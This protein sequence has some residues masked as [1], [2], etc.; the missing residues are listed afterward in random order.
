MSPSR[1]RW[2]SCRVGLLS[3][4]WL[5]GH[6]ALV[7]GVALVVLAFRVRGL[8]RREDRRVACTRE[9]ATNDHATRRHKHSCGRRPA[10]HEPIR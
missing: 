9:E 3:L 8:R 10:H 4:V 6:Y 7:V 1:Q 2:R 5:V